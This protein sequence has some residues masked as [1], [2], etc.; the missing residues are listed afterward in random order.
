MYRAIQ[1]LALALLIAGCGPSIWNASDLAVWVRNEAVKKGCDPATVRIADWYVNR[2][3]EN[4]WPVECVHRESREPMK[5]D[6]GVD[7]VWKPSQ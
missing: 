3:G 5:L 2:G 7:K 6:I 1:V 4:V